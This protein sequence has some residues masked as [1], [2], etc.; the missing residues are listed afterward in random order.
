MHAAKQRAIADWGFRIADLGVHARD[1]EP[2]TKNRSA[3]GL[4]S[5]NRRCTL[6]DADKA[7]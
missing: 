7:R 3:D 6:M 2:E 5:G 1:Q 4:R